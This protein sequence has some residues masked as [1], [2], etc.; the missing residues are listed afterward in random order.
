MSDAVP[1]TFR[2][3]TRSA[4]ERQGYELAKASIAGGTSTEIFGI[5]SEQDDSHVRIYGRI[6]CNVYA[7]IR[8]YQQEATTK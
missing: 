6:V 4:N 3:D 5:K 2:Y 7:M 1:L 8:T